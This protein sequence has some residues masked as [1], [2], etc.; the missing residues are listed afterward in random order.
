MDEFTN[1]PVPENEEPEHN[2]INSTSPASSSSDCE[3][4]T[5]TT[6]GVDP[7][8]H[9]CTC[10]FVCACPHACVKKSAYK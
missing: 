3:A 6:L 9:L 2:F 5:M 1:I 7:A 4:E 10:I 8:V